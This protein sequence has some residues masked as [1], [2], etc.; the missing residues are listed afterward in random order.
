MPRKQSKPALLELFKDESGSSD[1]Q[2]DRPGGASHAGHRGQPKDRPGQSSS[3]LGPGRSIRITPG[4]LM[5]GLAVAIILATIIWMVAY[6]QGE[7]RARAELESS[8][9]HPVPQDPL[10]DDVGLV[11]NT[12]GTVPPVDASP[13]IA[14]SD[15]A[16]V[17][18]PRQP[19]FYYFILAETRL[20]G[21]LR[22]ARFCREQGLETWVIPRDTTGL[23]RVVALPGLASA[24]RNDPN[25]RDLDTRIGEIGRRWKRQGGRSSLE[26][27]YLV[28]WNG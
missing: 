9:F 11:A 14:E 4:H 7:L 18:D 6:R 25:V 22:L 28:L 24:T 17:G 8:I 26:D 19:G 21:A 12:P 20:D 10:Q 16:M 1:S 23:A 13:L 2:R 15:D 3:W 27:R 5:V